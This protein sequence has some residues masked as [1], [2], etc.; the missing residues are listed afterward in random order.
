MIM[1]LNKHWILLGI[2]IRY[3]K[4]NG[5]LTV[6]LFKKNIFLIGIYKSHTS[7]IMG[8]KLLEYLYC[9]VLLT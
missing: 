4:A 7:Y 3:I 5:L 9:Q 8:K 2:I 1:E 6:F